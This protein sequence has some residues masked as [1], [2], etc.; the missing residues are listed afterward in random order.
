MSLRPD[1]G[2]KPDGEMLDVIEASFGSFDDFRS[3]FAEAAIG[4]FGSGWAWLVKDALGQIRVISSSDAEN[5][6]Q[7]NLVPLV[8]LD[9]WEHAYYIDY[10]NERARYVDAFLD[11]LLNWNFVATNLALKSSVQSDA[12]KRFRESEL[13]SGQAAASA[14][15]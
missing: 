8:T 5:P 6:L 7:V 1:G 13:A 11:H 12:D 4:E 2:G 9:V 15:S 10:H 3:A 14:P